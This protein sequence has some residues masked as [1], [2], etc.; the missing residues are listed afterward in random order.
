VAYPLHVQVQL[1]C[2]AFTAQ[3]V[4]LVDAIVWTQSASAAVQQPANEVH[5]ALVALHEQVGAMG[6]GYLM[7]ASGMARPVVGSTTCPC[8]GLYGRPAHAG[9]RCPGG[10]CDATCVQHCPVHQIHC[11]TESTSPLCQ[12]RILL[13]T[14]GPCAGAA[15]AGE[16]D[17]A[18]A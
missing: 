10:P 12:Q 16:H 14:P 6:W 17:T 18:V 3:A 5:T 11:F 2:G 4:L 15:S 13:V 8:G 9:R 1:W 7:Q